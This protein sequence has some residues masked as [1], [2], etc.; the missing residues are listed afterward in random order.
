MP[1][2][3]HIEDIG[4]AMQDIGSIPESH[5]QLRVADLNAPDAG[6]S[7]RRPRRSSPRF[8]PRSLQRAGR[9]RLGSEIALNVGNARHF[10]SW[11]GPGSIRSP[12]RSDKGT[13]K[14]VGWG[15]RTVLLLV[16]K[17]GRQTAASES[18]TV[19]QAKRSP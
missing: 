7:A 17:G 5:P 3:P 16:M 2:P 19:A 14:P 13:G 8:G 18:P 15:E 1:R 11:G 9:R 6:R 10:P 12:G 4:P